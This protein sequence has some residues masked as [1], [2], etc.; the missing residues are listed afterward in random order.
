MEVANTVQPY[1]GEPRALNEDFDEEQQR[2]FLAQSFQFKIR[3]K[4][5]PYWIFSSLRLYFVFL[6]EIYVKNG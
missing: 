3:T 5:S 6:G 4:N 1:E 2:R